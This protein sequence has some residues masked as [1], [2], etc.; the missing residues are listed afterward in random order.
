MYIY[1]NIYVYMDRERKRERERER[2]SVCVCVCILSILA[3]RDTRSFLSR[4]ALE[5]VFLLLDWL[6]NKG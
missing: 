4:A 2:E 3:V 6:P 5:L 1:I